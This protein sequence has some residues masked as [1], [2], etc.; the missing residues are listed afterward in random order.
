MSLSMQQTIPKGA[1][2]VRL[3][4]TLTAARMFESAHTLFIEKG[5]GFPQLDASGLSLQTDALPV[6]SSKA[7]LRLRVRVEPMDG[8]SLLSATGETLVG[9]GVWGPATNS[10]DKAKAGF[11]EMVMLLGQLPH[12]EIQYPVEE[13]T[14]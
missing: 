4:S 13:R 7:P 3:R 8:G 5:F 11:Q 14:R 12:L 2:A 1:S 9:P 6:G 10:E